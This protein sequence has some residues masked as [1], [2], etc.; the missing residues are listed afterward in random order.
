[1]TEGDTGEKAR[2]AAADWASAWLARL[3]PEE[4]DAAIEALRDLQTFRQ[5]GRVDVEG[6]RWNLRDWWDLFVWL[7][8]VEDDRFL[9]LFGSYIRELESGALPVEDVDR[10]IVGVSNARE[11][12]RTTLWPLL[13]E[14]NR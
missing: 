9:Q 13:D 8:E 11:E 6:Q 3:E 10:R 1:M 7:A 4:A 14:I 5:V 2:S 12:A